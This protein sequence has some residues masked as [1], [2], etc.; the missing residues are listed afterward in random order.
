MRLIDTRS[1]PN[2][3]FVQLSE[4]ASE[5]SGI[6]QLCL[7]PQE[8][9]LKTTARKGVATKHAYWRLACHEPI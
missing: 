4:T 3:S 6:S 7:N 5:T 2:Y 9:H 8:I 1:F